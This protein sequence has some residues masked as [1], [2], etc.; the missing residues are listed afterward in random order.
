MTPGPPASSHPV[1]QPSPTA[2]P[3]THF[4]HDADHAAAQRRPTPSAATNNDIVDTGSQHRRPRCSG[5]GSRAPQVTVGQPRLL[6][7]SNERRDAAVAALAELFAD[8]LDTPTPTTP[9]PAQDIPD[10]LDTDAS[11]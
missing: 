6:P 3:L 9:Q 8:W 7:M 4:E 11:I 1:S 2:D 10:E 5:P